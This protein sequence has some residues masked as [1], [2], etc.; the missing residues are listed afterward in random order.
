MRPFVCA[1]TMRA[2]WDWQ[3]IGNEKRIH[4]S[5]DQLRGQHSYGFSCVAEFVW[6]G[7]GIFHSLVPV[8]ILERGASKFFHF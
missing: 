7:V 6:L 1:D 5:N 8:W 4:L 3:L 2:G